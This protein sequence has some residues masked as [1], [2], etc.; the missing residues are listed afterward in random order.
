MIKQNGSGYGSGY[1]LEH[2]RF[3]YPGPGVR[4]VRAGPGF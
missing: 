1:G 2:A 3:V 4:P